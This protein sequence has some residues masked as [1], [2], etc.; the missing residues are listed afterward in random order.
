VELGFVPAEVDQLLAGAEG[1]TAQEL[2]S[3][4]LRLSHGRAARS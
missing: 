4:A 1:D 3:A 2:I